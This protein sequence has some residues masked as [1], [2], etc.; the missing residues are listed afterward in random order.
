MAA[1]PTEPTREVTPGDLPDGFDLGTATSSYQ[2]EGAVTADGR[3]RSI[4]DA[5]ALRPGAISDG[6]S[7]D[8][9][10]DHY[11]RWETDLDLLEELGVDSYRF[12]VAWPRIQPTGRGAPLQ[13]GLDFY[14]RLVDGLLERGIRPNVTLYH[15]DLPAALE[16]DLG[17]WRHR[18]TAGRFA[19]YALHV[20]ERLGDRVETWAT[21]NEP[22]CSAFLGYQAGV[23]APGVR[24]E[25]GSVRAAHHLLVGHGLAT[26]A[27][28]TVTSAD[29]GIVLNL[30]HFTPATDREGDLDAA[31]RC[32]GTQNRWW[33]GALAGAFPEDVVA[34][35]IEPFVEL[36]EL[37]RDGDAAL[38]AEPIDWLGVNTYYPEVVAAGDDPELRPAG[39]GLDGIVNVPAG[40]D[41]PVNMLGWRIDAERAAAVLLQAHEFLPDL[42]ITV[43]ENGIP[44]R[45]EV[46]QHGDVHDPARV[47][48][49]TDHLAAMLDTRAQGVPLVG[50]YAWS[51]LDNFEWAHGY[52]PRFGIVH[53]DYE[54]Q[55]RTP[56]DSYRW[57]QELARGR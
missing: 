27:L 40:Q 23:H 52:G 37:T 24:D 34:N 14:D 15:W 32:D 5:L 41:E 26:Q 44:L 39:P 8:P 6:T 3:G 35:S 19:D 50:Y 12:S 48:Y 20:A 38:C 1:A 42:P 55:E 16:D 51:M 4:W 29:V 28:R 7:G 36:E 25:A 45:D 11:R 57:L 49:L 30:N 13:A 9:A 54:T 21:L 47:A 43:T 56:K 22:W 31:E 2:I 53:V 46:D 17:G 33:L 18:D 10:C